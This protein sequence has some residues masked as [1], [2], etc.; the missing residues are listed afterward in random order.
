MSGTNDPTF[1][2]SGRRIRLD[3]TNQSDRRCKLMLQTLGYA[4][5]RPNPWRSQPHSKRRL[6]SLFRHTLPT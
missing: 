6:G 3:S 1:G 5:L 4:C 2:V